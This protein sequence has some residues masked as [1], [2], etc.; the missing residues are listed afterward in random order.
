MYYAK[1][2]CHRIFVLRHYDEMYMIIH[3]TIAKDSEVEFFTVECYKLEV[4]PSIGVIL[5]YVLP[6]VASLSNMMRV[7]WDY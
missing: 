2:L 3:E 5:K 1:C 7:F 4:L 6:V